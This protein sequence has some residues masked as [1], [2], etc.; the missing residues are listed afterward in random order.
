MFNLVPSD[1]KPTVA[2]RGMKMMI[3][4]LVDPAREIENRFAL[5]NTLAVLLKIKQ[6]RS[7]KGLVQGTLEDCTDLFW[8]MKE[9]LGEPSGLLE[10]YRSQ[11]RTFLPNDS[12]W[13]RF[14]ELSSP[15]ILIDKD[16]IEWDES[17]LGT[18]PE[19]QDISDHPIFNHLGRNNLKFFT[20]DFGSEPKAGDPIVTH[21][22]IG[23]KEIFIL[24]K[25]V[26][27]NQAK[28]P[29]I[30]LAR[31][32]RSLF[33]S[34][35][36]MGET[37]KVTTRDQEQIEDSEHLQTR[38]NKIF[39]NFIKI[40]RKWMPA[41][42]PIA[43][44]VIL[45]F[46][47]LVP[48]APRVASQ[49]FAFF[50]E[51]Q[52][53][54]EKILEQKKVEPK[55]DPE[56]EREIL[57]DMF[58][59]F[60]NWGIVPIPLPVPPVPVPSDFLSLLKL[61]VTLLVLLYW[62]LFRVPTFVGGSRRPRDD[63]D[64]F[65]SATAPIRGSIFIKKQRYGR[66]KGRLP[67]HLIRGIYPHIDADGEWLGKLD[68]QLG[69]TR[70]IPLRKVTI[71]AQV[72]DEQ[73]KIGLYQLM[74]G[75]I[76]DVAVTDEKGNPA[77][78]HWNQNSDTVEIDES[79]T[80]L[81]TLSWTIQTY[82]ELRD[83][84]YDETPL[85]ENELRDFPRDW[86]DVLEPVKNST[87]QKKLK[88][89][90]TLM[91][92][93]LVYSPKSHRYNGRSWGSTAQNLI[94]EGKY[95]P[96]ICDTSSLYFYLMA[97]YVRLPAAYV[98]I[99]STKN[100]NLYSNLVGHAGV[101][102]KLDG[103][104]KYIETTSLVP[105]LSAWVAV[106]WAFRRLAAII[107]RGPAKWFV[108]LKSYFRPPKVKP[109]GDIFRLTISDQMVRDITHTQH[110]PSDEEIV[111]KPSPKD[112][113]KLL[114]NFGQKV[115]HITRTQHYPGDEEIVSK[116]SFKDVLKLLIGG[117]FL[118]EKISS[119][120]V[121]NT[122]K[123]HYIAEFENSIFSIVVKKIIYENKWSTI[124]AEYKSDMVQINTVSGKEIRLQT[125]KTN[126]G[127]RIF[128]TDRKI[129]IVEEMPHDRARLYEY[130]TGTSELTIIRDDIPRGKI[131]KVGSDLCNVWIS[132]GMLNV[133]SMIT[134]EI[135]I[136]DLQVSPDQN[137]VN[138]K[139]VYAADT[140][141]YVTLNVTLSYLLNYYVCIRIDMESRGY[142]SSIKDQ[143]EF[144]EMR[145][146]ITDEN[147]DKFLV[148]TK[149]SEIIVMNRQEKVLA[150]GTASP[151]ILQELYSIV[152]HDGVYYAYAWADHGMCVFAIKDQSPCKVFHIINYSDKDK[153]NRNI[154]Q[155]CS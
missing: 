19:V 123:F 20:A 32:E 97:R 119:I 12:E 118:F 122:T 109:E 25:A 78:F 5:I 35:K 150:R 63:P 65:T 89:I 85:P 53:R 3:D 28:D 69:E 91:K 116:L 134:G 18:I 135:K 39:S 154:S 87:D 86:K 139:Q 77:R 102:T 151:N 81:L 155:G 131:I 115:G 38:T 11:H 96:I 10:H 105:H 54:V 55:K 141:L 95:I 61:G 30:L 62:P 60:N 76:V 104:W 26:F 58:P 45:T 79:A 92:R 49:V 100:G 144:K 124:R 7:E 17:S 64:R 138:I 51:A 31:I 4:K 136:K 93:Y 56:H 121:I 14:Q 99:E 23:S 90:K 83:L 66:V 137:L 128:R 98:S 8:Y 72:T 80:G 73:K 75:K 6:P 48:A 145:S 152:E 130:R 82:S 34:K 71:H 117:L 33:R 42:V 120:R 143:N 127:L 50:H 37:P 68:A 59:D 108:D 142:N 110:Y 112:V 41:I 44:F 148:Q 67:S 57:K 103:K 74:D 36:D 43:A 47:V 111:S 133:Q 94:D 16:L 126:N 107:K 106:Y 15:V 27:E 84:K 113:L 1:Q 52:V 125:F 140:A 101:V 149:N 88:A 9:K 147:E 146:V 129:Y 13:A 29:E 46:T 2:I 70:G 114:A 153:K 21:A 22:Q 40:L 24:D 132:G